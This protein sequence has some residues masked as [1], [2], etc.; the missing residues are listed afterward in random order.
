MTPLSHTLV[1]VAAVAVLAL[2]A[3]R[4]GQP[5]WPRILSVGLTLLAASFI[6]W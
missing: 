2:S 3:W 5:E 6:S 1:L 4:S